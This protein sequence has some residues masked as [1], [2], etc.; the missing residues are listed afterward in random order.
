MSQIFALRTNLKNIVNNIII[1]DYLVTLLTNNGDNNNSNNNNN[2]NNNKVKL[3]RIKK[4]FLYRPKFVHQNQTTD[5]FP[6]ETCLDQAEA[7]LK[8]R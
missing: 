1:V 3:A 4:W 8:K 7:F 2:N 5:L 6:G